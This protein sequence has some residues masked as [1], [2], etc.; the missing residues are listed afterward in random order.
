[1]NSLVKT[2]AGLASL[3]VFVMTLSGAV[4]ASTIEGFHTWGD[5]LATGSL[6]RFNPALK[7]IKYMV[8]GLG[9]FGN[10][11][12]R[13]SLGMIRTGLGYALTDETSVW[14]GY[15][16]VTYD[17]PFAKTPFDEHRIW[18]DFSG[19]HKYAYATL[20]TRSRL[21]Q[22]FMDTGSQV[23][24]RFRQRVKVSV[25]LVLAPDFSLV[26][27]DE[28][29]ANL[30]KTNFGADDGFDQ[31]RVFAGLGYD[32]NTHSKAEVGYMNNYLR[33][34]GPDRMYHYLAVNVLF[35]Y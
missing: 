10:D 8:E 1:M 9:R 16:W 26:G 15:A 35:K 32:F 7:N 11:S 12:S 24:W 18:Q 21:E 29:F 30:N 31:N 23:G 33:R 14:L 4:D 13:L 3:T 6:G 25:P 27:S 28:F 34:H 17:E 5:V 2:N 22:R 19:G 20:S